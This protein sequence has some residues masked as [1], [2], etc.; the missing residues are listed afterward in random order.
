MRVAAIAL[1]TLASGACATGIS[2]NNTGAGADAAADE[3]DAPA[4]GRPDANARADAAN[5]ADAA[6]GLCANPTNGALLTF[7]FSGALGSQTST[8]PTSSAA[9]ITAGALTRSAA[10]TAVAGSGSINASDWATGGSRD[11]TRYYTFTLTP[12]A[13]CSLDLTS[14]SIDTK[15]STSGPSS[16]A[17]ATSADAFASTTSFTPNSV[18]PVTLAISG[19]TG[20][21]EVRVYGFGAAATGGTL[22]IQTTLTVSGA[23]R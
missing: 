22:R 8:A 11:A 13:G 1:C 4:Q 5:P 12:D 6:P 16:A 15:T 9:G 3:P 7:D 23:L 17:I 19:E 10:L 20:A 2:R 21:V 18:A 14:M